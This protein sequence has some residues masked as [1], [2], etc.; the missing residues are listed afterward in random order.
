MIDQSFTTW[1]GAGP[2]PEAL[3]QAVVAIGNFDGVHRGHQVLIKQAVLL[4][5]ELRTACAALTFEP[6]PRLYFNPLHSFARLTP[7]S[8]KIRLFEQFHVKGALIASFDAAFADMSA[9]QFVQDFLQGKLAFKGAVI[10]E[11]FRFG[12]GREGDAAWL[13]AR[14]QKDFIPCISVPPVYD[15]DQPISSTRIRE[16]LQQGD[17]ALANR[18]LGYE[19][20]VEGCVQKGAQRGRDL[21]FPTAN[22]ALWPDCPLRHGIYAVRVMIEGKAYQGAASFGRRPT[23]DNGV[24]LLEVFLLD[25]SGDL[26]GKSIDIAFIDWVRAEHAFASTETLIAQ[27]H[28][29]VAQVQRILAE[30]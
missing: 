19:W 11:D 15:A 28:G 8:T 26:Y 9:E 4:A 22:L 21:G 30:N 5:E 10:G 24:P 16:A 7:E 23:F 6:H 17:V 2:V 13:G 25:F 1:R 12:R 29:D 3:H 18:L 14:L 20:W 27:M